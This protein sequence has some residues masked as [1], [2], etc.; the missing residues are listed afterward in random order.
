MMQQSLSNNLPAK[1]PP[2]VLFLGMEGAFS[3]PSLTALLESGIDVCAVVVPATPLPDQ[4][5]PVV[6]RRERPRV[7][8]TMLP[9]VNSSLHS[10]IVQIAWRRQIP[11]WEVQRLA[12][13]E[14]VAILAAYAPDII[15][16][17]CFSLL[18]PRAI[19]ELP[20]LGCLNVHPS[21][22]PA[23]RGPIPLF[24]TF[25]EGQNTTG[26][27]IHLMDEKMDTG[28]ILVQ[29]AIPV[30]DG[31]NYDLLEAQCAS[32]GGTL[33]ARTVQELYEGRATRTPQNEIESSYQ[34]FPTND[35]F[36][37]DVAEWS[38]RH[39]YNFIRG[40][41]HWDNAITL[42]LAGKTFL[43]YAAHSYRHNGEEEEPEKKYY[44]V[45]KGEWMVHCKMGWVHINV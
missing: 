35:D 29:H 20:H 5:A 32:L 42:R 40:V 21:L 9:L 14:V 44:Q 26:V 13:P 28:D 4:K 10:S 36:V 16:V 7:A 34:T 17:S 22:L 3:S 6:R 2:R 15:C 31:I 11:V 33:L 38:A 24:W 45:G 41:G 25:R 30:P 8:R 43:C 18:I 27:T 19:L 12:D 37:I 23:N 39:V 1:R